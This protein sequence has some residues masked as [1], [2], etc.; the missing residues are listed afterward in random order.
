L[1]SIYQSLTAPSPATTG[2]IRTEL[3]N[4]YSQKK[5][6][7]MRTHEGGK[8]RTLESEINELKTQIRL[9]TN[10]STQ[11]PVGFDWAVEFAEVFADGGF[12]IQV[13]NP[14][15]VRQE[16]IKDL[17]PTLQKV[18]PS[19]YTGT[20]DLYCFFYARALQLLKPGGML[21][22]ISPNKWFRAKYGEKLR[23]HIAD[24]CHVHSI[25][26]FGELPVFKTAA[27][28]PMIFI[29]QNANMGNQSTLFTQVKSL[30]F[31]YPNVLEIIR[32][33]GHSLPTYALNGS[34]W[35]L[36]NTSSANRLKKMEE[37][38]IPLGEYVEGKIYYGVKT[39][40]N[41]AFIINSAKRAELI[42]QQ[43]Q[44]V[45]IIK[46]LAIGDDIRK[47]R[48]KDQDRWLIF[49]RRGIDIDAYPVI[50]THLK[51][52]Q[53]DLTPKTD[54]RQLKGRKP[55]IYKWYEIQDNVA[56]F[57]EFDKPKIIY[58]VIAKESRFAFDTKSTFTNDKAFIIP[59]TDY[60]LLGILNSS[61]VW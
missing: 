24:N 31:P 40:F 10:G 53:T 41:T 34:N 27:T 22:F 37:A 23:K 55:G 51:Q 21:A 4:Q 11:A 29:A 61:S 28:F 14:P 6:E 25:T 33:K 32:H 35:T 59:I 16:L 49:T 9:I 19:V 30:E 36:T 58:P 56:Y 42:A 47:W 39:G 13:A 18:Y 57:D 26:D 1:V 17:K 12:D 20:S 60:Y 3:V 46:P 2:M 44:C 52:W 43:P 5:A 45:D 7:Y 50:K 8:K 38:G 48:I 15:Y 54:N